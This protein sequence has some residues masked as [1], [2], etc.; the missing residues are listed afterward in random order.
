MGS[1]DSISDRRAVDLQSAA[2]ISTRI[3]LK[4]DLV[5]DAQSLRAQLGEL[6]PADLLLD[7]HQ[8]ATTYL[9]RL[10]LWLTLELGYMETLEDTQLVHANDMIPEINARDVLLNRKVNFLKF[11]YNLE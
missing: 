2:P 10:E 6:S 8:E 9:G 5:A 11:V 4:Q 7:L 1:V 3:P